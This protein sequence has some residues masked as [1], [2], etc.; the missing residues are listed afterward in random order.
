MDT[1][2]LE[3]SN[4]QSGF[5]P[6]GVN[7][8]CDCPGV[9]LFAGRN[10]RGKYAHDTDLNN[11]GPRSGFAYRATD[12]VVIRAGYGINYNGAYA[13]AVPFTQFWTSSRT[14]DINSPDGG[15]TPA[16]ILSDGL[17]AV[18][19]FTEEDRVGSLGATIS[20]RRTVSPDL[21]QQ[22]QQNGYSPQWN[23]TLQK[24]LTANILLE[25]QY[26]ANVGHRLGV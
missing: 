15:F 6:A 23:F 1:P 10:G 5:D 20:G 8:V 21:I 25:A 18:D 13:R 9:M 12:S 3:L 16:F 17:P 19:P 11:L 14:L 24:Q 26:Q 2:R 22:N 4:N 7:P